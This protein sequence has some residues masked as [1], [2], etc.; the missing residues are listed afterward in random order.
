M[1]LYCRGCYKDVTK[2]MYCECSGFD[3]NSGEVYTQEDLDHFYCDDN[4]DCCNHDE[5]LDEDY[6]EIENLYIQTDGGENG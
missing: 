3:L 2:S 6:V 5:D 4:C 1:N